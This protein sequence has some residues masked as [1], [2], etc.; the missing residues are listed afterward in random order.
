MIILEFYWMRAGR[1]VV[2]HEPIFM[3]HLEFKK[4]L[5]MNSRRKV[6]REVKNRRKLVYED[7]EAP[8]E[9]GKGGVRRELREI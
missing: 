5:C 8:R 2:K 9:R 1:L 3:I 6:R 4:Q 7:Y